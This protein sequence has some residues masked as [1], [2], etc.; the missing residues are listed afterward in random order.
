MEIEIIEDKNQ[1]L[2]VYKDGKLLFYSTIKF[3]WLRKNLIKI[4]DSNDDLILELQSYEPVFSS[5]KYEILFQDKDKIKDIIEINKSY[6]SNQDTILRITPENIF[7]FN[8][9]FSYFLDGI[10]VADIKHKFWSSSQ[11]ISV[12]FDNE[13]IEL[14]DQIIIHILSIHTGYNSNV[15]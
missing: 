10:K 9:D 15:A 4:F 13:N 6:I 8:T 7:S 14:L 1:N 2:F 11:K 3:N 12:L 5:A